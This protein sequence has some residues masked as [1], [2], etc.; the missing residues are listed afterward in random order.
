M[1]IGSNLDSGV[2]L[3][4]KIRNLEN[5]LL[6]GKVVLLG[7]DEKPL[8]PTIVNRSIVNSDGGVFSDPYVVEVRNVMHDVNVHDQF[9]TPHARRNEQ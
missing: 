8:K 7:E 5:Q 9:P 2:N 3:A 4:Y 6:D 1:S